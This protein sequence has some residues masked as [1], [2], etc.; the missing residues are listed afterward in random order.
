MPDTQRIHTFNLQFAKAVMERRL[1]RQEQLTECLSEIAGKTGGEEMLRQ[2]P[3]VMVERGYL[4]REAADA[5]R[6]ELEGTAMPR[7]I[8]GYEIDSVIGRGGMGIVYKARSLKTGEEVAFKV[9]RI[10]ALKTGTALERFKRE[11][12]ALTLLNHP[13]ITR[14]IEVGEFEGS[15]FIAMEYVTGRGLN[16]VVKESGPL[17]VERAVEITI[18]V[19]DA[20]AYAHSKQM[21]H[22]DIKP[23]NILIGYDN[24]V[25][26]L[27]FGLS[28]S[29]QDEVANLT[30]PGTG[31]GTP[32]YMP[33]EQIR[34]A[35][36]VDQRGDIYS[37]GATL[38]EAVTG[39]RTLE[40]KPME[41][42]LKLERGTAITPPEELRPDLHPEFIRILKKTLE[43][44]PEARYQTAD[45]LLKDLTV[46]RD[47][48]QGKKPADV[49]QAGR[50]AK[51]SQV[52]QIARASQ[53]GPGVQAV[54]DI[55]PGETIYYIRYKKPD[56]STLVKYYRHDAVIERIQQERF[57]GK[58]LC[59]VGE[60]GEFVRLDTVDEFYPYFQEEQQTV[61]ITPTPPEAP[62]VNAEPD[63]AVT[64]KTLF[65][66]PRKQGF[67]ARHPGLTG[68]LLAVIVTLLVIIALLIAFR[69]DFGGT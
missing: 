15:Q 48:L 65:S 67:W 54:P 61:K 1:V 26:L 19:A 20:L 33:P 24:S 60:S 2:L 30:L 66:A 49:L 69:P 21:I 41:V 25:K 46:L 27:D 12:R 5:I 62:S 52:R 10:S 34:G 37:L 40:G 43:R 55:A 36:T 22:R 8:G 4:S 18:C 16:D 47:V 38:Y 29:Q 63:A 35:K 57:K 11:A 6:K 23:N 68:V 59:R 58:T 17:S 64:G 32:Y 53:S 45:D 31:M 28:K 39:K 9:V 51:S 50:A 3:D 13:N 14:G 7:Q 56:G 42:L 44:E